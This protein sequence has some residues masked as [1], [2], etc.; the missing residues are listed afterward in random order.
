MISILLSGCTQNQEINGDTPGESS[1]ALTTIHITDVPID[2]F[3]HV[4]ITF[5]M[6]KFHSDETGWENISIDEENQSIVLL[7]LHLNNITES[8]TSIELP[9][10][11]Y[12]KLWLVINNATGMLNGQSNEINLIVASETLKIQQLFKLLEGDNDIT[13]EIDL[14]ASIHSYKGGKEYKILLYLVGIMH[15]HNNKIQFKEQDKNELKK[16]SSK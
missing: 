2:E 14:N 5:S 13:L 16:Q 9:I 12:T 6:V 11:N 10:A 15:K 3:S 1:V 7:N 4:I 8:L